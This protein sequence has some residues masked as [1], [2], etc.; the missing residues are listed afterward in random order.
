[1]VLRLLA[2]RTA[3]CLRMLVMDV[4]RDASSQ[5][6]RVESVV[7]GMASLLRPTRQCAGP[8]TSREAER[9]EAWI[10]WPATWGLFSL[11]L[12]ASSQEAIQSNIQ[13][14]F[15]ILFVCLI[16][17]TARFCLICLI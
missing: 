10:D 9:E 2:S 16:R 14:V 3:T 11:H 12:R 7:D 17:K 8:M 1:M 5:G 6:L 15:E 13:I 4:S